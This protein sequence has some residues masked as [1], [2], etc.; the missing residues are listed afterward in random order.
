M[1]KLNNIEVKYSNV[2]LVLKGVS[3]EVPDGK[4]IAMLGANG[5]GKTSTLKAIS[6]LLSIELGEVTSGNI[7]WDGHC[8]ENGDPDQISKMG[9][10]QVLEGHRV[11]EHLT[12]EENI[13]VVANTRSDKANVKN[14]WDMIYE[15]FPKLK[16]LR[17]KL[18]GYA[19]GG[20][21]QMLVMARAMIVR[22]KLMMLDEPSL[23]LAPLVVKDIFGIVQRFNK[24]FKSSILLVEQNVHLALEVASY[25]YVMEDGRV[26]LDGSSEK[27][28]G[29][30]D[31]KEFYLGLSGLGEKK[32]YHDVKHYK[33]RR[34]WLG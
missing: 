30:E 6:G 20:E 29:N 3:I 31:V 34:R 14:D 25:G 5:A 19:S 18:A 1:L 33:R 8:I 7:E 10:V 27:L 11:F 32:S 4:I 26:V 12:V 2:I 9:I 17:H 22:P 13:M 23:G 15:Y 21:Q 28:A 24:E 16:D